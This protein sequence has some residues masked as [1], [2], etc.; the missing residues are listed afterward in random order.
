MRQ[1]SR[2][3]LHQGNPNRR[4]VGP[5][6]LEDTSLQLLFELLLILAVACAYALGFIVLHP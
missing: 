6:W 1:E 2:I 3:P 5:F 4:R